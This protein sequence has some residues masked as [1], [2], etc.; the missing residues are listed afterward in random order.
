M[1]QLGCSPTAQRCDRVCVRYELL[2]ALHGIDLPCEPGNCIILG[3]DREYII[4]DY[5]NPQRLGR[6]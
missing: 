6:E 3:H 4:V 1:V 2:I 5:G